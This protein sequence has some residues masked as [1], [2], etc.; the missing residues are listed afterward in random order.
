MHNQ[1]ETPEG[2]MKQ[3]KRKKDDGRIDTFAIFFFCKCLFKAGDPSMFY[4]PL[5]Y[6]QL[7]STYLYSNKQL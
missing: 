6:L 2:S 7:V 4:N 1:K 3:L 5:T